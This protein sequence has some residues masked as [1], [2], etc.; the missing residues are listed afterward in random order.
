MRSYKRLYAT[1]RKMRYRRLNQFPRNSQESPRNYL[2]LPKGSL[3]VFLAGLL[4]TVPLLGFG[5]GQSSLHSRCF[6]ISKF[7]ADLVPKVRQS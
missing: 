5:D 1:F 4:S 3:E 7:S 2:G 6:S